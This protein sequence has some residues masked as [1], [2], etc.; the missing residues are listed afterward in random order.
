VSIDRCTARL[1]V[2][3]SSM[4]QNIQHILFLRDE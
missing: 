1:A 4:V 3:H 2:T